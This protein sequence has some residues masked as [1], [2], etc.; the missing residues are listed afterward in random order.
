MVRGIGFSEQIIINDDILIGTNL[1]STP[2][3]LGIIIFQQHL[4]PGY[5]MMQIEDTEVYP[6]GY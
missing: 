6:D 5:Y 1:V 2:Y 3:G 4:N